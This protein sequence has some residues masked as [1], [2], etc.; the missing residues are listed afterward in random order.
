MAAYILDDY[1]SGI[2]TMKLQKLCF[3]SQGWAF[4][5]LDKPLFA[6][7][8]QA[9]K[10]GPVNYELFDKHRGA[11][12][13]TNWSVGDPA[14]LSR[15]KK[16][17]IDAVLRNYGSL[18]GLQLSELT[19]KAGT[20]WA[21]ARRRAGVADGGAAQERILDDDMRQYFKNQLT[22]NVVV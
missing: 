10:N 21:E 12:T 7:Y 8:F 19:H 6:Q 15:R 2:S 5:L 22:K 1:E 17:V 14:S 11:F 9:W 3:F 16:L 4:A 20:P 18:S 13:I